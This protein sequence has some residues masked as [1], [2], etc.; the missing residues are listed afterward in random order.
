MC[1]ALCMSH[2]ACEGATCRQM[3]TFKQLKQNAYSFF[4]LKK[5]KD[6]P[7]KS[8]LVGILKKAAPKSTDMKQYSWDLQTCS[9]PVYS[10]YLFCKHSCAYGIHKKSFPWPESLDPTPAPNSIARGGS[11]SRSCRV[12]SMREAE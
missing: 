12:G 4:V 1:F 10:H 5:M 2:A 9:C 7:L 11:A 6:G 3:K 8:T